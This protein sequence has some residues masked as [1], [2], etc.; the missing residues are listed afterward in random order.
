[1]ESAP[2][3]ARTILTGFISIKAM[4]GQANISDPLVSKVN[5]ELSYYCGCSLM[6]GRTA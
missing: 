4:A 5:G 2:L 6:E 1:M 3:T